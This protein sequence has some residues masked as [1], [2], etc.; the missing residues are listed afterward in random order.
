MV[1]RQLVWVAG[2]GVQP[3]PK[4][5]GRKYTHQEGTPTTGTYLGPPEA[6]QARPDWKAGM[7]KVYRRL[8]SHYIICVQL[9]L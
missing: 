3:Y 9:P 6:H 1:G 7:M 4:A 8:A 2:S 5:S